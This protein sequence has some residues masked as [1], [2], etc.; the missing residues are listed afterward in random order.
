MLRATLGPIAHAFPEGILDNEALAAVFPEWTADKIV[1]KTGIAQRHVSAQGET[2]GDLGVL[3]AERLFESEGIDR[4]DVDYLL[5]CTQSPD[6]FLPTTA[7]VMQSR[8]GLRTG[9]GALDFNLGCSGYIYGLGMAK[10]LIETGQAKNVLLITADTYSK[11]I[12]PR[13]KSVRTL[14]GD[15]GAAT[16]IRGEERDEEAIG[17]FL[18]GTDGK[19]AQN[20]IVPTGGVREPRSAESAISAV[21]DNGSERARDNLYMNGPE[22]FNFTLRTVPAAIQGLLERSGKSM[23]DID[24]FVFHQANEYMLEH[25]RKKIGI[26]REKFVVQFRDCGNTVSATIPIALELSREAGQARPGMLAMFVGFGVGYSWGG[27]LVRL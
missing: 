6:Y 3:A 27:T 13:D 21:D 10:G 19:G 12:H 22:I 24:L 5:F 2:A 8:L 16:L 20:L 11:F 23:D 18:Y 15:A 4:N 7:C 9:I 17:P 14:F 25:L 26:P 1:A